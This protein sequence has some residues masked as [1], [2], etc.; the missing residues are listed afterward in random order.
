MQLVNYSNARWNAPRS[1]NEHRE[2][3][4]GS[5]KRPNLLSGGLLLAA[6]LASLL[7]GTQVKPHDEVAWLTQLANQGDDGAQLQLGLAYRDGRY[8]LTADA[9]TGL[10]WLKRSAA[11]GNAYAEDAVGTA[12]ADGQG[13]AQD[14]AKAESWW[15]KAMQDGNQ[16]ARIHLADALIQSGHA[17][18]GNALLN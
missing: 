15:R 2:N 12:Y 13:I 10:Y 16:E 9:K 3:T 17:A 5:W 6:V 14:I 7:L 18:E 1:S 4:R 11:G 8:G